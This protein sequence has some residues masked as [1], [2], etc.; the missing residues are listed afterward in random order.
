MLLRLPAVAGIPAQPGPEV[1]SLWRVARAGSK[2][3]RSATEHEQRV[4]APGSRPSP[5]TLGIRPA[6]AV[7]RISRWNMRERRT[8][9]GTP[10]LVVR[11]APLLPAK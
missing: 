2:C 8:H 11:I 3:A 1:M 9:S 4:E 10:R 5:L 7:S 6:G